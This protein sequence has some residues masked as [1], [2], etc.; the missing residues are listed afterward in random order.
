MIK[1]NSRSIKEHK[2]EFIPRSPH[3]LPQS[4]QRCEDLKE[5]K[6]EH[7]MFSSHTF[8]QSVQDVSTKEHKM[9][10]GKFNRHTLSTISIRCDHEQRANF[11]HHT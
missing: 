9:E 2:M 5:H 8:P 1:G 4:V 11:F 6:M 7:G 10:F 3:A